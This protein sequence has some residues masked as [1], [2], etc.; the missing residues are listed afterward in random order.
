MRIKK[1][2]IFIVPLLFLLWTT[3]L[4][5]LVGPFYQSRIDPEYPYLL[6]SL[7]AAIFD[8]DRIGHTDHPGTPFQLLTAIFLRLTHLF[9]GQGKFIDD[10]ITRPELYLAWS[11]FYITLL[12]SVVILWL[13]KIVFRTTTSYLG[14]ILLQSSLFLNINLIDLPSRYI[15][16]RMLALYVLILVCLCYKYFYE[17]DYSIKK[18]SINSG[19]LMGIG[20]MTKIHF[21]PLLIIPVIIINKQRERL[22]YLGTLITTV[23]VFFLP[24]HKKFTQFREFIARIITHDGLYGKGIEQMVNFESFFSNTV[25]IFKNNYSFSIMLISSLILVILFLFKPTFRRKNNKE[26]RMLLAFMI[27]SLIGSIMIAKHY[28]NYYVIPLVSFSGFILYIIWNIFRSNYSFRYL[29][30]IFTVL[31]LILII[32]PFVKLVPKY[33]LR[34]KTHKANTSFVNFL[35][36][37]ISNNDYILIKPAWRAGPLVENG[38]IY[39]VSFVA[40]HHLYYNHFERYYSNILTWEGNDQPMKYFRM[41]NVDNKAVLKSG[42][43]IYIISSPYKDAS[44]LGFY[45]ESYCEQ[46]GITLARDTIYANAGRKEYIIKYKNNDGWKIVQSGLCG[47]ERTYNQTLYTNDESHSLT[48]SYHR[49]RK[50]KCNGFFSLELDSLYYECPQFKLSNVLEGDY[51]E[52]T[53]KRKIPDKEDRDKGILVINS[54]GQQEQDSILSTATYISPTIKPDWRLIRL[55]A[56]VK[57]QPPDSSLNCGFQY[58]GKKKMYIDDF[59]IRHFSKRDSYSSR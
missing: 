2:F 4:S 14:V 18:F 59:T 47:F 54:P 48:G 49:N 3:F 32:A 30:K 57:K 29:N 36:T 8:F 20:F 13:G 53:V 37:N 21:L 22:I 5:H 31:L 40:R 17:K 24:I 16:D 33:I 55:T 46:N 6:N 44:E 50:F 15:P 35:H 51:I 28:K 1:I 12:F 43:N 41:L 34:L 45:L 7:G 27:V 58:Y 26:F 10:V 42:R 9:A 56:E 11:S 38:L 23:I 52:L 19:I 25:L 39:G